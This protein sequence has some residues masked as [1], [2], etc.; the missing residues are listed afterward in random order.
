MIGIFSGCRYR[1][2]ARNMRKLFLFLLGLNVLQPDSLFATH[3]RL[4]HLSWLP[5]GNPGEVE[6][7][8]VNGFR[9]NDAEYPGTAPDGYTQT[10]DI[11]TEF[12]GGTAFNFGDGTT[13]TP[14]LQYVVTAYSVTEDYIICEA[15]QPGTQNR[16]IRHTYPGPGPF[17]AGISAC[18]RLNG[19]GGVDL[20]NRS[21]GIYTIQTTVRPYNGNRSPVAS[22]FPI[23]T[24]PETNN[25]SFIVPVTDQNSDTLRFRIST[26]AEAGGGSSP[27]N[28]TVNPN[29]GIVTWNTVGL[30][31]TKFWTVQV[32]A[33]DLDAGLNV[34]SKIPI[35]FLLRISTNNFKSPPICTLN[36]P[37]PL[38]AYVGQMVSFTISGSDPDTN[39]VVT[40]NTA[41]LPSG[42]TTT[43]ALPLS[44]SPDQAVQSTFNWT[45]AGTQG[46]TY[47]MVFSAIDSSGLPSF[48]PITL[49][50]SPILLSGGAPIIMSEAYSPTNGAVDPGETITLVFSIK[51]IGALAATNVV[52][53][54]L[55]SESIN[56]PSEPQT[57]GAIPA[58]DTVSRPFTFQANGPCGSTISAT[59][60]LQ[61]GTNHL[62]NINF[63]IVLG[64]P[65]SPLV[66]DFDSV[67]LPT[68]PS[69][70][71]TAFQ[72]A[73]TNWLLS[74]TTN[75]TA[76][77]SIFG[78]DTDDASTNDLTSPSVFIPSPGSQLSF[79]HYYY[80]EK[81]YDYCSLMIS[82]GG[83]VFVDILAAG[84]TFAT[85]GYTGLGWS[86]KSQGFISTIVNLPSSANGQNIRF[87]WRISSDSS[88]AFEGWYVDSISI[89]GVTCCVPPPSLTAQIFSNALFISWPSNAQNYSLQYATNLLP[90]INWQPSSNVITISGGK[91]S[92]SNNLV[93]SA[94]FYRL[95]LP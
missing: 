15:L 78:A 41:G 70:W 46:G 12:I 38:N 40:L 56:L 63:Q 21:N 44:G 53:T 95:Y 66:Q 35:D 76:P 82:V 83:G 69:G 85:N 26:D 77:N 60:Q 6:F 3:F 51:N 22:L 2:Y 20:N 30:D 4:G 11:I 75:D 47:Q 19:T 88:V 18:C 89:R 39:E 64:A 58:N 10:G 34:K 93:G 49:N 8:L 73:G 48:A 55:A 61:E 36:P 1:N 24:V 79:R 52:A 42:A 45:P 27:P 16:Y 43:P 74:T 29:T 92:T 81:N 67:T 33:E 86:G 57:Y 31:Q 5:T 7:H 37:S 28:L 25:A 65:F 50:I 68:L 62:G 54:L 59:L 23:I 91:N 90:P 72:G 13:S 80:T 94:R 71:T 84:G 87:R 14:R 32:I 9:R 17:I